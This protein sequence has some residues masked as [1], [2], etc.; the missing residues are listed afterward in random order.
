AL[1][2]ERALLLAEEDATELDDAMHRVARESERLAIVLRDDR[3]ATRRPRVVAR[4]REAREALQEH[5]ELEQ[6][7]LAAR[8]GK[9]RNPLLARDGLLFAQAAA[10]AEQIGVSI[11]PRR[12]RTRRER[13]RRR[14]RRR[15]DR[16]DGHR[17]FAR[18]F[19][20][21]FFERS[22]SRRPTREPSI[23]AMTPS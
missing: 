11:L 23:F 1:E 22:V 15:R 16:A 14:E 5:L 20:P 2:H 8:L 6:R 10:V 17:S 7:L 18:R 21:S 13:S 3:R 12:D 19:S 4:V 9:L